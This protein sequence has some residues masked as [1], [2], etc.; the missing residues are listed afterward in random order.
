MGSAVPEMNKLSFLSANFKAGILSPRF[1]SEAYRLSIF[2]LEA[3]TKY[4]F[5]FLE[6]ITSCVFG[7]N[8]FMPTKLLFSI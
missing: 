1:L 2:V 6:K 3:G 5:S 4:F 7:S 8:I